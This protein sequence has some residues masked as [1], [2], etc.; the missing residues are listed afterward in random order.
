M[1]GN[2]SV[3]ELLRSQRIEEAQQMAAKAE[4]D[5][6]LR[7]ADK[8]EQGDRATINEIDRPKVLSIARIL[9]ADGAFERYGAEV[10]PLVRTPRVDSVA[11]MIARL[12]SRII[13]P[14][15][16][17]LAGGGSFIQ[18][19]G[20]SLPEQG[21]YAR[22]APTVKMQSAMI[23]NHV[24][25]LRLNASADMRE[26]PL[27]LLPGLGLAEDIS[28]PP[29]KHDHGDRYFTSKTSRNYSP[30]N[31]ALRRWQHADLDPANPRVPVVEFSGETLL[32][33]TRVSPI[34][35]MLASI[36]TTK[37]I[38]TEYLPSRLTIE[39]QIREAEANMHAEVD[40]LP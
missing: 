35:L 17:G 33:T 22:E 31:T 16:I 30:T 11:K 14:R 3:R 38:P 29:S 19:R 36:A 6:Q 23:G 24:T 28:N 18:V 20:L 39:E 4:R 37:G 10:A 27:Y 12:R 25:A 15:S 34:H 7:A 1:A 26:N 9:T 21:R 13:D 40:M 32:N 8:A 5:A 2:Q